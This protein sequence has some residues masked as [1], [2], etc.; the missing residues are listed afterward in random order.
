MT[1]EERLERYEEIAEKKHPFAPKSGEVNS[2]APDT[3]L[4]PQTSS[5]NRWNSVS[6][7]LIGFGLMSL[8]TACTATVSAQ[9]EVKPDIV[10]TSRCTQS[11]S[12]RLEADDVINVGIS[13]RNGILNG[14][15]LVAGVGTKT[16][17]GGM[18]T[19]YQKLGPLNE[20]TN[21]DVGSAYYPIPHTENTDY[22]V[23]KEAVLT[24]YYP[25]V[26]DSTKV[27]HSRVVF[28]TVLSLDCLKVSPEKGFSNSR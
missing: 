5:R 2:P 24:L 13:D 19:R 20:R 11:S 21:L 22:N 3:I 23:D 9:S 1:A 10:T 25:D 12:G 6:S 17:D 7:L 16:K 27:D 14:T 4:P 15:E 26:N 18:Y 28:S 8:V